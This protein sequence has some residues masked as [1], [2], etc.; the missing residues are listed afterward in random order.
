MKKAKR[1]RVKY[2]SDGYLEYILYA[3]K[4]YNS[5]IDKNGLPPISSGWIS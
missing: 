1:E 2:K 5:L 4:N 3:L